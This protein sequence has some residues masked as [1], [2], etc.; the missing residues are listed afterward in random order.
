MRNYAVLH[1]VADETRIF[2]TKCRTPLLICMEVFRPDEVGIY[3]KK[4]VFSARRGT[5]GNRKPTEPPSDSLKRSLS[6]IESDA[7]CK[8]S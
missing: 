8:A 2:Q 6:A 3:L 4:E 5:W 1:I 7:D